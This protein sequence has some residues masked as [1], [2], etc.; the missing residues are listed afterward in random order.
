MQDGE[1][2]PGQDGDGEPE[3]SRAKTCPLKGQ[4]PGYFVMSR[5]SVVVGV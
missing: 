3:P 1:A 2:E 5:V 4:Q